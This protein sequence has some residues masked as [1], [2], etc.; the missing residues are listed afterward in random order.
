MHAVLY[1]IKTGGSVHPHVE[2]SVVF[3][4]QNL[5]C[6]RQTAAHGR[7]REGHFTSYKTGKQEEEA[8]LPSS[9]RTV[10]SFK[11]ESKLLGRPVSVQRATSALLTC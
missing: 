6:K 3:Y 5:E 10:V 8:E 9:N 4:S 7:A 11:I 1:I 2:V